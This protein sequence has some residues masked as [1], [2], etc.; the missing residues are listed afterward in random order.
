MQ[1]QTAEMNIAALKPVSDGNVQNMVT[2]PVAQQR[3]VAKIRMFSPIIIIG[4][5]NT[6]SENEAMIGAPTASNTAMKNSTSVG[7][8]DYFRQAVMSSLQ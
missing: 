4:L 7:F 3:K 6:H 2:V 5:R 8:C 1:V